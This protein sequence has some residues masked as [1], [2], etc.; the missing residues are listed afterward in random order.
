MTGLTI[1]TLLV[2]IIAFIGFNMIMV[3]GLA[4]AATG[5]LMSV[6]AFGY[7][8]FAPIKEVE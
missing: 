6:Y 7:I 1:S 5:I 2:A 8:L 4:F 3:D